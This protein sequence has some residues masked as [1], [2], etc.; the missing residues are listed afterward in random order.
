[1]V[2]KRMCLSNF[3]ICFESFIFLKPLHFFLSISLAFTNMLYEVHYDSD[4]LNT[5]A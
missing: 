3:I 1:M 4:L 2:I 5:P